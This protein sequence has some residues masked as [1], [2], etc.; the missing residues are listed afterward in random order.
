MPLFAAT[1]NL[2]KV[3]WLVGL[4]VIGFLCGCNHTE[5]LQV[6]SRDGWNYL[7]P[8]EFEKTVS[9]RPNVEQFVGP[10][11]HGFRPNI[12]IAST[13]EDLSVDEIGEAIAKHP[14][15]DFEVQDHA[16]YQ[17]S[18][19]VGYSVKGLRQKGTE[20]QRIVFLKDHGICV[21]FTLTTGS[22]SFQKWDEVFKKSLDNFHWTIANL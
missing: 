13:P 11:D 21:V 14:D 12:V 3:A 19:L 20:T 5:S 8:T 4:A 16:A 9:P 17:T 10:D 15:K 18:R 2:P 7:P 22:D 1:S 6:Q